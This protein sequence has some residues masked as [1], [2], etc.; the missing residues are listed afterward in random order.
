MIG[1]LLLEKLVSYIAPR[2][3]FGVADRQIAACWIVY[4]KVAALPQY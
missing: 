3:K 1:P 4:R 2:S